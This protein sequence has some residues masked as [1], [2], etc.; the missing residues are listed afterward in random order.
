VPTVVLAAHSNWPQSRA[1][2]RLVSAAESAG[3]PVLRVDEP[4]SPEEWHAALEPYQEWV[5]LHPMHWYSAPWPLKKWI[6][7]VLTFGWAYGDGSVLAGRTWRQAV[8]VGALAHEYGRL[9]S[10]RYA[11]EEFLRPFERT[12]AFCGMEWE[13]PFVRYGAGIADEK[14]RETWAREFC[15]FL[16]ASRESVPKC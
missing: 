5:F 15:Q 3:F 11:V 4:W 10:R 7:E 16:Q 12:A 2:Q 6:D 14:Q 1:T 13:P 9:G 8:L